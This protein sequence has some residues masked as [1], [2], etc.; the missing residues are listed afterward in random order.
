[1]S[2]V[3]S[4]IDVRVAT[5]TDDP[6]LRRLLRENPMRGDISV[7]LER[8]PDVFLAGSTEGERHQTIVARDRLQGRTVGMASRSVYSGFLNGQPASLG[9]L[10]QLR[11]DRGY[12]GRAGL[13]SK[14]YALMRSLRAPGDLPFDVTS[15]VAD[16]TTARRVLSAG[17]SDL[18]MYQE[19][20]PFTTLLLPLWRR[21]HS[22]R[23]AA[24]RIER[25]SIER[26]AAV[27][28]CLERNRVRYQFSPRWTHSDLLS[29]ERSRG[30]R[31]RDFLVAEGDGRVIGC[32]AVW[33]QSSFKQI[34]V[35]EYGPAMQRWR[36]LAAV[37]ARLLGTPRL[38]RPGRAISHA[39]LSHVAVDDDDAEVFEALLERAYNMA[40]DAG[41]ACLI[42]GFADRHPFLPIVQRNYRS[43]TYASVLY[44][45]C[46][47]NGQAALSGIDRRVP[48]L[49]VGLL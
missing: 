36:P 18:P 27:A 23:S 33:N 48:H 6:D 5:S 19:L 42:V 34:V 12:R 35:R 30:L 1:M 41:Y 20:E 14:G 21:R 31:P 17:L 32:L 2:A 13:L 40:C 7:S 47:E 38:P 4:R 44:A 15:I 28:D 29:P 45:V 46:W 49:E 26:T 9:Y 10:S 22:R 37:A 25:G 8:E 24:V 3:P 39:Y 43:W 16:N 11:V